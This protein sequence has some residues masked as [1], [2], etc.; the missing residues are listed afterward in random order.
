MRALLIALVLVAGVV[1]PH[2]SAAEDE[3]IVHK[4][5]RSFLGS[6]EISQLEY[7]T[8]LL[9][10]WSMMR[11]GKGPDE[12]FFDC[13]FGQQSPNGSR[14]ELHVWAA[15]AAREAVNEGREE[16][17]LPEEIMRYIADLCF[18]PNDPKKP[19]FD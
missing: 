12:W 15:A 14:V 11:S 16:G 7:V 9:D 19:K 6:G 13:W 2:S 3:P 17:F 4:H 1:L 5:I 10:A 8:G 18:L